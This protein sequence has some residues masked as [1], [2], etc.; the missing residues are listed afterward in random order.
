MS[1]DTRIGQASQ[2]ETTRFSGRDLAS[3]SKTPDRPGTSEKRLTFDRF[4]IPSAAIGLSAVTLF[5]AWISGP[6]I[7]VTEK[8][9][10]RPQIADYDP[11]MRQIK[12]GINPD[13]T[14]VSN[15][16]TLP[17]T[18]GADRDASMTRAVETA[19]FTQGALESGLPPSDWYK[20]RPLYQRAGPS[21]EENAPLPF[22]IANNYNESNGFIVNQAQAMPVWLIY[23]AA[24]TA[25]YVI[26]ESIGEA[27][28]K[29]QAS[30][31]GEAVGAGGCATTGPKE[32]VEEHYY[33]NDHHE[34][35]ENGRVIQNEFDHSTEDNKRTPHGESTF[36]RRIHTDEV[37]GR[38]TIQTD[39]SES[40]HKAYYK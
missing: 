29:A 8:G 5:S 9:Q 22:A 4:R 30:N 28:A 39:E 16:E 23:T 32:P 37:T 10:D 13:E 33:W 27:K 34:Y 6:S 31:Q 18:I 25:I 2:S 7:S 35:I 1:K 26:A 20:I 3:Q 15:Q 38:R 36:Q 40:G 12:L 17:D 14:Q 24:G 21:T 11:F 19:R